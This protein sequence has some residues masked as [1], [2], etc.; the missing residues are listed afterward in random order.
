MKMKL[1]FADLETTGVDPKVNAIIQISGKIV[2][3]EEGTPVEKEKFNFLVRP[4]MKKVIEPEAL[5]VN[6]RSEE[7]IMKFP[8]PSVAFSKLKEIFNAHCEQY[9][10]QDKMFFV[11]Y[12]SRFDYDFLRRFW[13]DFNDNYFGSY[14]WT[15]PVDV[16]NMAIVQLMK[17]R[18]S[19][20][21]F[22]LGTVADHLKI[23]ADGQLHDAMTDINL[24]EKIFFHL[25]LGLR[26]NL[27][28]GVI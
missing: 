1:C 28:R 19:L 23:T 10:K 26:N 13:E 20:P 17:E 7:E 5:K 16:M 14:F 22:K 15:P 3:L 25:Y 24:T 9:N 27:E 4:F 6:N 18:Q 21:N 12:N 2:F 11:G 8:A